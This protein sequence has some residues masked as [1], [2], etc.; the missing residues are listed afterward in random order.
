MS[1][2]T[3][4]DANDVTAQPLEDLVLQDQAGTY[5]RLTPELLEQARVPD[6]RRAALEQQLGE[7]D[8]TTGYLPWVCIIHAPRRDIYDGPEGGVY[9]RK[10]GRAEGSG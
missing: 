5:Y 6:E 7:A 1:S 2:T 8:D 4:N 9:W 10:I 3:E